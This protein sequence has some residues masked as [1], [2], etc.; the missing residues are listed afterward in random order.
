MRQA[1]RY[2]ILV[3]ALF[4][5]ACMAAPQTHAQRRAFEGMF[6]RTLNV[7]GPVDLDVSTGSGRI[8]VRQGRTHADAIGVIHRHGTDAAR[9]RAVHVRVCREA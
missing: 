3:I 5:A 2:S 6:D 7:S 9:L 1:A 4:V 8:E